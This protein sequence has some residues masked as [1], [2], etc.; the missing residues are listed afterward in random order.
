MY[1][2]RATLRKHLKEH[3]DD[4]ISTVYEPVHLKEEPGREKSSH[5]DNK[6]EAKISKNA[7]TVKHEEDDDDTLFPE[8]EAS[9]FVVIEPNVAIKAASSDKKRPE[10]HQSPGSIE[11]EPLQEHTVP[12]PYT[13]NLAPVFY[14]PPT[15]SNEVIALPSSDMLER[16]NSK[17]ELTSTGAAN[18]I[19]LPERL[20]MFKGVIRYKGEIYFLYDQYLTMKKPNGETIK[21]AIDN[22]SVNPSRCNCLAEVSHYCD[23]KSLR[24]AYQEIVKRYSKCLTLDMLLSGKNCNSMTCKCGPGRTGC[25]KCDCGVFET[26]KDTNHIIHSD[27]EGEAPHPK[28]SHSSNGDGLDECPLEDDFC[29]KIKQQGKENP[30]GHVCLCKITRKFR[31]SHGEDCGHPMV[32]HDGHVDYI[33]NGKLHHPDGGHCDDHGPICYVETIS[34]DYAISMINSGALPE[35]SV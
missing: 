9:K 16:Q 17:T 28:P 10:S 6:I 25:D 12:F 35:C 14:T 27:D 5:S 21:R 34:E 23:Y 8:R 15:N 24:N 4:L 20:K 30:G 22:D 29:R 33:V 1:S 7:S 3:E 18:S 13:F 26:S 31:H 11:Q 19:D 32:M 2:N